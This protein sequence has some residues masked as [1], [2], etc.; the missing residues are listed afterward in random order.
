MSWFSELTPSKQAGKREVSRVFISETEHLGG[1][2]QAL[3][4][5]MLETTAVWEQEGVATGEMR[6]IIGAGDEP[7]LQRMILVFMV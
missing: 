7:F 4:A 2:M 1:V 6:E 3:E 5:A